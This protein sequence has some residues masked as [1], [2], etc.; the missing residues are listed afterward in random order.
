MTHRLTLFAVLF[1]VFSSPVLAI[2][3]KE[4]GLEIVKETERR[5]EGWVNSK[6]DLTM[7]LRN[8]QGETSIRRIRTKT[9]EVIDNGDKN[10]LIFNTP[11][12]VKD[13]ALLSVAHKESDDDQWL[14]LPALKRVKRISSSNKGG[15]FMGSEFS[16][17]DMSPPVIEK[18]T[19][20]FLRN[21]KYKGR[22][23]FVIERFPKD[24]R[25]IYVRSIIWIDAKEYIFWK[26]EYYNRRDS[27]VKTLTYRKY[28]RYLK[29]FWR[30]R[31]MRMVNHRTGKSTILG[32][33]NFQ[34]KTKISKVDFNPRRLRDIR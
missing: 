8:R 23:T 4:K 3:A 31:E 9:L 30:P 22:P 20:K 29:D 28:K 24:K 34:F 15:A 33:R 1:T 19:Y 12:D 14:F 25:S 21:E 32:W 7:L 5:D 11:L 17:E 10:L 2:T 13:T 27:H 18:Y 6:A 16:Y 26:T